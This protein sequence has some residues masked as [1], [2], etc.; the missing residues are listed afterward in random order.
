MANSYVN[1]FA[2]S[3]IKPIKDHMNK[4]Y[5]CACALHPFFLAVCDENWEGAQKIYEQINQCEQD[6]DKLKREIRMILPSGLFF[7][8][9][10]T[11]LLELVSQQDKIANKTKDIAGRILGRHGLIP[12]KVKDLMLDFVQKSIDTVSLANSAINEIDILLGTGFKGR[13][14]EFVENMIDNLD[15]LEDESDM[16]E[17]ELRHEILQIEREL[18]PV[19]AIVLYKIVEWIGQLADISERTG[20][21]LELMLAQS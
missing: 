19:D 13:V 20:A 16:L 14:V 15:K 11:D 17:V 2:K 18:Y 4:V 8:V 12:S 9:P 21:R 5:E 3:P 10:R 7:P 1:I 6:A